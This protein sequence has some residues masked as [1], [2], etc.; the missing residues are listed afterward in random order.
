[1]PKALR[2]ALGVLG[3]AV[4]VYGVASLTGRWLGDPPWWSREVLP[5]TP[6][7]DDLWFAGA[8]PWPGGGLHG[9]REPCLGRA[10]ISLGVVVAGLGLATFAAWPRRKAGAASK[11]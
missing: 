10:W 8:E 9:F 5:G 3:L 1:M 2:L 11:A 6:E 7:W 4:A